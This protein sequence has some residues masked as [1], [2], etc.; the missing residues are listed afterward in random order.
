MKDNSHHRKKEYT[1]RDAA[2][3]SF[4]MAWQRSA[5]NCLSSPFYRHSDISVTFTCKLRSKLAADGNRRFLS[6]QAPGQLIP[7]QSISK[8]MSIIKLMYARR[9]F[10][11][12]ETCCSCGQLVPA[13]SYCC[14]S[15]NDSVASYS[16]SVSHCSD[17]CH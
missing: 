3:K 16:L 6:W 5:D 14:V 10:L 15:K 11:G 8:D 17:Q 2:F 13:R 9:S 7:P 12:L 4:F 1:H